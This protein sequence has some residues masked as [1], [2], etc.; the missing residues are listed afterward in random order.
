MKPASL[1]RAQSSRFRSGVAVLEVMIG[2]VIVAIALLG[3]AGM[4]VSASRRAT[5]LSTQSL[6]DGI[7]LQ[8]LNKLASLPYDLLA[9]QAGCTSASSGTLSYSRC[10]SITDVTGGLGY[11]RVR[12]IVS[13]S[14]TYARPETVYVN[15]TKGTTTSPFGS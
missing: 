8:E 9:N 1:R 2:I 12:L 7:V 5:G 15:R 10:I 4:T 11:K 13:P 14:T 3:V 6:R